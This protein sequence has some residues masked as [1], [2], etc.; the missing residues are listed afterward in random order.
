MNDQTAPVKD[1]MSTTQ[2]ALNPEL[3]INEAINELLKNGISGAPVIDSDGN[4]IGILSEKDCLKL[5]IEDIQ[6]QTPGS[7]GQVKD[8]MTKN[9]Q[10]IASSTTILVAAGQF[11]NSVYHHLPVL[12]GDKVVG[13]ISRCDVLR[14]IDKHRSAIQSLS[15]SQKY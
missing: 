12:D 15:L 6:N 8:F 1:Y 10:S 11:V 3:E 7:Q 5:L 13:Q 2:L 9:A 4:L 14:A